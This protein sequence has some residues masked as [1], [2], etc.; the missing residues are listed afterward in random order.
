MT[1]TKKT[2]ISDGGLREKLYFWTTKS[3]IH[4]KKVYEKKTNDIVHDDVPGYSLLGTVIRNSA[5]D[6]FQQ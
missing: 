4:Y 2:G 5:I 3:I 6:H 1:I